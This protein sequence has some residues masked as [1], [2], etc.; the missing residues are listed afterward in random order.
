MS[1]IYFNRVQPVLDRIEEVFPTVMSKVDVQEVISD[2]DMKI[3]LANPR[4]MHLHNSIISF[5]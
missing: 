1:K 3:I 5:Y 4:L 2:E